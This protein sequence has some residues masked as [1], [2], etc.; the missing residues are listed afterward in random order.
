MPY[1][2]NIAGVVGCLR[3]AITASLLAQGEAATMVPATYAVE[4]YQ[5]SQFPLPLTFIEI[6]HTGIDRDVGPQAV[7]LNFSGCIYHARARDE[8]G[9]AEVIALTRLGGIGAAIELDFKLLNSGGANIP[10][11]KVEPT[12]LLVGGSEKI[13]YALG[14]SFENISL[15]VVAMPFTIIWN[16]GP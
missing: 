4:Q 6:G 9:D 3:A 13:M 1:L 2:Y 10:I 7:G 11:Q 15:A 16:E 8:S 5:F 12:A 14:N